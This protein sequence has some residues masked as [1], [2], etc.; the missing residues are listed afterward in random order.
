MPLSQVF[1]DSRKKLQDSSQTLCRALGLNVLFSFFVFLR[2]Q[3]VG[4]GHTEKTKIAVRR[5]RTTAL[6]RALIHIIPVGVALWEIVLNW[7]TYFVG[8]GVYN[9][10]Y[11]QFGAKVH[12]IAIQAS[13]S[14]VIFS[15]VSYE[16][17][18][19]DGI[20][21]GALFSGLQ[22]SQ[23]SYL[24]SMEFWGTVSSRNISSKN[25]LRL[26]LVVTASIFLA[27][28]TGPSSAILLVPRLD[29]WPAG[30]T[31]VWINVTSDTLWPS[32]LGSILFSFKVCVIC[33][34]RL[35]ALMHP[36]CRSSA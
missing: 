14:A 34:N 5:S 10:A 1:K 13:L 26:L 19:G 27:A 12:E 16:L 28:V 18:L 24:W 23:V 22:I 7:N 17:M 6:L 33:T 32:R 11:Y 25:K 8:Y 4:K 21:F 20:P 15:Y 36:T 29:Y 3:T 2:Y 30:S 9:L 35:L 31:H